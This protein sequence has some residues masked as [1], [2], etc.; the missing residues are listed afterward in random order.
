MEFSSVTAASPGV[1]GMAALSFYFFIAGSGLLVAMTLAYLWYTVGSARLA[2]KIELAQARRRSQAR[3]VSK[4]A[5][6][7]AATEGG[8]TTL[9]KDD[10]VMREQDDGEKPIALDRTIITVGH[11]ASILGWGTAFMLFVSLLIRAIIEQHAP[12]SN[13]YEFSL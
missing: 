11:A 4:V 7:A 10:V 9:V 8:V 6:V 1:S 5:S 3:K 12:W 2:N 13:L